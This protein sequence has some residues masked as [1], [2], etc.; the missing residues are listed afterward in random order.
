MSSASVVP[1]GRLT[2]ME[3]DRDRDEDL[4]LEDDRE[5]RLLNDDL[6]D[7]DDLQ[8]KFQYIH[9]T[10]WRNDGVVQHTRTYL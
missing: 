8:I 10:A 4:L 9:H 7:L 2:G 1:D 5:L 6:R 3:R